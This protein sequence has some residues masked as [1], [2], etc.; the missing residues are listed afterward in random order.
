MTITPLNILVSP[1]L[2]TTASPDDKIAST[3]VEPDL[4]KPT[5]KIGS[6]FD[7]SFSLFSFIKLNLL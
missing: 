5:I 4:G 1:R 2:S 6:R 7:S 3:M